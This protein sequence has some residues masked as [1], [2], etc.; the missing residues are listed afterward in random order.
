MLARALGVLWLEPIVAQRLHPRLQQSEDLWLLPQP[1]P[2]HPAIE[3]GT[4]LL[5]PREEASDL[6][7]ADAAHP[8]QGADRQHSRSLVTNRKQ[9]SSDWVGH[10]GPCDEVAGE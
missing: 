8:V 7:L 3:A 1:C 9:P 6:C 10:F 2:E 5:V 4:D